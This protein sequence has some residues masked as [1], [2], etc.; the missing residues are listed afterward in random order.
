MP[1]LD[2][3]GLVVILMTFLSSCLICYTGISSLYKNRNT[4]ATRLE[5]L[6]KDDQKFA[7]NELNKPLFSRFIRPLLDR[8]S[9]LVLRIAPKEIVLA[10]EEKVIKAGNPYNL[11]AKEWINLQAILMLG[12]PL[13]TAVIGYYRN[14][15][16]G[17]LLFLSMAEIVIALI[18]PSIL[19]NKKASERQKKIINSLPDIIDLLTVCVEAGL[20]FDG[21]LAKVIVKMRGP[22]SDEFE[23]ALQE[24]KVGKLKKDA[25]KDMAERIRVQDFTTF[26]S[27]IVQADQFGVSIGN[28]LRIHAEQMR[29]KRVQ[30]AREKAMKAP[31]KILFPMIIFIFPAIFSVILGPIAIRLINTFM[32]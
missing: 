13:T 9:R 5:K 7:D 10:Y 23:K 2:Y 17:T 4:I 25:L 19:L 24:I 30:D 21:A 11:S 29:Q 27:A 32:K 1:V 14:I 28:V 3:T 6:S 31:V 12:L 8:V 15:R 18:L 16:S 22:L 26:I 20:G